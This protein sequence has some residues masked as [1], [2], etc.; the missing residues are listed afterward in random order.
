M[1]ILVIGCDPAPDLPIVDLLRNEGWHVA[2]T[3]SLPEADALQDEGFDLVLISLDADGLD[4]IKSLRLE[5]TSTPIIALISEPGHEIVVHALKLGADDV[6]RLP[7]HPA[8]L[9]ARIHAVLRRDRT[10][11]PTSVT[12]GPMV[13]HLDKKRVEIHGKPIELTELE[14][15]CLRL[16]ARN[17]GSTVSR[18]RIC[19]ELNRKGGKLDTY[20][21]SGFLQGLRRKIIAE[22]GDQHFI[23][24]V[25][26]RGYRLDDSL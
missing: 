24:I 7:V 13:V 15:E 16:L 18:D 9:I 20:I 12:T 21:L 19:Y 11:A 6:I 3:A 2:S 5:R 1:K 8:E 25:Y 4:I 14:R 23:Q 22:T 10:H 17:K 26:G